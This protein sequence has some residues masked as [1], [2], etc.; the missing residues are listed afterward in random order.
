MVNSATGRITTID[1]ETLCH[2]TGI[3]RPATITQHWKRA[4]DA[5]PLISP[6]DFRGGNAAARAY[7]DA[8]KRLEGE[9]LP[10]VLPFQ[11]K[12]F[13]DRLLGRRAA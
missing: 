2:L 10:V 12:T 4:R 9:D 8:A 7:I 5:G 11:R 1:R 6:C 3:R 13:L